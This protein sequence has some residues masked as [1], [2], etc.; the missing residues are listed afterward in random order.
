MSSAKRIQK[1]LAQLILDPLT[2]VSAAPKGDSLYN[3]VAT[4][5]GPSDSAYENGIFFVDIVFPQEYP[6]KPPK[7]T[8]KTRIY[9]CNISSRCFSF[10]DSGQI[11]LDILKDQWS[12]ALSISKVL[13]SLVS[14]LSDANPNDPLVTN[15]AHQFK[16]DRQEHDRIA[17]EWVKRFA[18]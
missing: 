4:I 14:L 17:R 7:L 13:L 8:F 5:A 1:E 18:S 16:S 6:F 9:H 15:I 11:C 10:N 3:W 12:P 2:N